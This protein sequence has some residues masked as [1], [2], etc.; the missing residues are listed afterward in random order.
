VIAQ[1]LARGVG[2]A[3][4]ALAMVSMLGAGVAH[5]DWRD[6]HRHHHPY[7]RGYYAPPPPPVYYAPPPAPVGLNLF[8]H[9][10]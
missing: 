9:I 5:A 8:F 6:H 1:Q 4:L 2:V 10:R 7:Y 3:G